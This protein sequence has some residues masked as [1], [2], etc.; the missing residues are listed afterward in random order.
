MDRLLSS[1]KEIAG[2]FG[3]GVRTV[4]RWERTLGLPVYR[5]RGAQ[6]NIVFARHSELE[7]WIQKGQRHTKAVKAVLLLTGMAGLRRDLSD[8]L[9]E[10]GFL[11]VRCADFRMA[12]HIFLNGPPF[13]VLV[14]DSDFFSYSSAMLAHDACRAR[15]GKKILL[16][17]GAKFDPFHLGLGDLTRW[18]VFA[19]PFTLQEVLDCVHRSFPEERDKPEHRAATASLDRTGSMM[20]KEN[21]PQL[22]TLHPYNN[23]L[24]GPSKIQKQQR[25]ESDIGHDL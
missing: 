12:Q 9:E 18:S 10:E 20:Q 24:P 15:V 7:S 1:W 13:D 22:S 11:V 25:S 4:Q 14:C 6:K 3:K 21:L 17:N 23:G 2:Y 19:R 16:L 5:P 8:L